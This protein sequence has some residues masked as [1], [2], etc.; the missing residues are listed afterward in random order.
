MSVGFLGLGVMGRPMALNLVGTGTDLMVWNRTAPAVDDLVAAGATAAATPAE[1]FARCQV[2]IVMLANGEVVDAVLGRGTEAFA[3]VRDRTLVH[4][5]TTA[6]AYSQGLEAD[7]RAAG[8]HY[9]EAPV[10]G[11]RGP[12]ERAELVAMLA[13]DD[14]AVARVADVVRPMCRE[15]VPCGAVPNALVTK[16]TVNLFL[17]ATVTALAETFHF[18]E[19][20]GLDLEVVRR[21]LD[22][23]Q[24]AST[25]SRAKT[26]MLVSGEFPV[27]AGLSDVL[28]NA[29]LVA[30]RARESATAAPL[31]EECETLLEEAERLGHGGLDMAA[32]VKAIAAR[33]G[34]AAP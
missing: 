23:G 33:T 16:L 9:V 12:A 32:V 24:M 31:I 6:A 1:V 30:D 15:V 2:V 18:A 26:P 20:Q 21:V 17:I 34:R 4:M 3:M 7:V 25:V 5:G 14:D 29:R 22:A 13:G 19:R 10:S 28:Y 8:G 27:Q 11:S